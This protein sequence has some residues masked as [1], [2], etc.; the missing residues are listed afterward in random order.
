MITQNIK[1]TD[2]RKNWVV[3]VLIFLLLNGISVLSVT[4]T[5][6]TLT[7]NYNQRG[8][9]STILSPEDQGY[10]SNQSSRKDE[11]E[12]R[13][14]QHREYDISTRK[15][16]INSR[17]VKA[18]LFE[19]DDDT[20]IQLDG[21]NKALEMDL[22]QIVRQFE[23]SGETHLSSIEID[24]APG[25][26]IENDHTTYDGINITLTNSPNS[27]I[28]NNTIKNI[29]STDLN[30][31]AIGIT[32]INCS[33]S[34]I[35][36]NT[37]TNIK[38]EVDDSQ[39]A[40][41]GIGIYESNDTTVESN[42]IS[43]LNATNLSGTSTSSGIFLS[44]SVVSKNT[45]I[46]SNIITNLYAAGPQSRNLYF[47][48]GYGGSYANLTISGNT[49]SNNQ[50]NAYTS[51]YGIWIP[52]GGSQLNNIVISDNS[53]SMYSIANNTYLFYLGGDIQANITI[54]NNE[55]L[56]NTKRYSTSY[57]IAIEAT[58]LVE[59]LKIVE[60]YINSNAVN[61]PG[62]TPF[63]TSNLDAKTYGISIIS[64]IITNVTV[65]SNTIND[66]SVDSMSSGSIVSHA[67]YFY[68]RIILQ[69]NLSG[70]HV[71]YNYANGPTSSSYAFYAHGDVSD[72]TIDNN[73]WDNISVRTFSGDAW[74]YGLYFDSS[75][76]MANITKVII[77]NNLISDSK[78]ES[79]SNAFSY[80]IYLHAESL[81]TN[82]TVYGNTF[83]YSSVTAGGTAHSYS[84]YFYAGVSI[85]DVNTS[86]NIFTNNY[87]LTGGTLYSYSI[88]FN[89]IGLL[90]NTAIF[91]NSFLLSSTESGAN[92]YAYSIF[93]NT[94]NFIKDLIISSNTFSDSRV[95]AMGDANAYSIH[96]YSGFSLID[97]SIAGNT[98]AN[99][100]V[101]A[102][103]IGISYSL[104][105]LANDIV[106]DI[107]IDANIFTDSKVTDGLIL[108][109]YSIYF[110]SG[111][112]LTNTTILNNS[113]E[114]SSVLATNGDGYSHSIYIISGGSITNTTIF[115]NSFI[116]SSI[117]LSSGDGHSYSIY[118]VVFSITQVTIHNNN[119]AN[120]MILTGNNV[121]SRSIYVDSDSI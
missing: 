7:E 119:F 107:A 78:I 103:G 12:R 17:E 73:Q 41:F 70:N 117:S 54:T 104:C 40:A 14:S 81:L 6:A 45:T 65:N 52:N 97:V 82:S 21:Q 2:I 35:H 98:F 72:V 31:M 102:V 47:I 110:D 116:D 87:V 37:I 90:T 19:S 32:L 39:S 86:S 48:A 11:I 99:S 64:D 18:T 38:Q 74:S 25:T 49:I 77:S 112:S 36:N 76:L 115:N 4:N 10:Q 96:V 60:N 68:A 88:Y 27:I 114:D 42:I 121:I 118:L 84:I 53:F 105:L 92:L 83:T 62:S 28:R 91:S 94:D 67:F 23:F 61:C 30:S 109:S 46:H 20:K 75:S 22:S 13:D 43:G 5:S 34:L 108:F 55:R 113:F 44:F 79:V 29:Y 51:V 101:S 9:G 58:T 66:N 69:I 120:S 93:I 63:C 3:V 16:Q 100:S 71:V 111:G 89:A 95:S 59:N 8:D 33:N 50:I 85:A 56:D 57:G 15:I 80:S 1:E 24:S 26:V 106:T